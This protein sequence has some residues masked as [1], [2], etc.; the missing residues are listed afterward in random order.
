MSAMNEPPSGASRMVAGPL[1]TRDHPA[2]AMNVFPATV[3]FGESAV[4]RSGAC[5]P[6]GRLAAPSTRARTRIWMSRSEKG[7]M[8]ML[9]VKQD[10]ARNDVGPRIRRDDGQ[11]C[12]AG[13]IVKCRGNELEGYILPT[14]L[15]R[16]VVAG[17]GAVAAGCSRP[18]LRDDAH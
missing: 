9:P 5:A 16:W 15:S 2:G 8:N 7:F 18:R 3:V 11:G 4:T 1:I 12:M 10:E 14:R 6:T 13:V 17:G